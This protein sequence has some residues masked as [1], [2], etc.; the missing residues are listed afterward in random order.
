MTTETLVMTVFAYRD[1]CKCFKNPGNRTSPI[2]GKDS[3][4]QTHIDHI[5]C[6]TIDCKNI[7]AA[8]LV[9]TVFTYR[10]KCK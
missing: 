10:H 1:K 8:T 7:T 2:S 6:H 4:I 9:M 3:Y 5:T